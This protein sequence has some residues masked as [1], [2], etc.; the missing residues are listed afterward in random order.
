M[1]RE[2]TSPGETVHDSADEGVSTVDERTVAP[3]P[4]ARTPKVGSPRNAP[5]KAGAPA[6]KNDKK[7]VDRMV[8]LE[9]VLA[10]TPD[11]ITVMSSDGEIV[12]AN[13]AISTIFGVRPEDVVGRSVYD[14]AAIH[15][16]DREQ[17]GH[18]CGVCSAAKS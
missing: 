15:P 14:M 6:G 9:S 3:S 2:Q 17:L 18:R 16:D 5:S 8:F 7:P 1:N 11:V 4:G 12:Y 13:E 10:G